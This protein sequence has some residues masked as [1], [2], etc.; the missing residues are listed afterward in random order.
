MAFTGAAKLAGV[1]GWPISHSLSPAL[2]GYW[3]DKYQID[4]AYVPLAV[5]PEDLAEVL[6]AL[7]KSGFAGVNLTLPH[8]ELALDLVDEVD[9]LARRVGAVN[10]IIFTEEKKIIG[11]NTDVFGFVANLDDQIIGWREIP[12]AALVIGAGGAARAVLAGLQEIGRH[13]IYLVNRTRHRAEKL[14]DD[15][16][17]NGVITVLDW[18]EIGE[19]LPQ[20]GVVVNTTALGMKGQPELELILDPLPTQALV[21]DIV[22]NPLET[23]LLAQARTRGH[24]VVD[25]LG[26]LLFQAQSGFEAWFG[27]KPTVDSLVREKVLAARH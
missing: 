27:Q 14:A 13:P 23:R 2:H 1:I 26:M 6:P 20:T 7:A 3:L 16:A 9:P 24:P 5:R 21:T 12:G 15:F 18:D 19:V 11:R 8:K 22:Y 4:G 25:G 17:E 10:T